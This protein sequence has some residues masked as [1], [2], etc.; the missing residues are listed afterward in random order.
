MVRLIDVDEWTWV[1]HGLAHMHQPKGMV[2]VGKVT[3][4]DRITV[5]LTNFNGRQYEMWINPSWV[6]PAHRC[7]FGGGM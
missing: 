6:V 7:P 1:E 5:F 4:H 3:E 2:K